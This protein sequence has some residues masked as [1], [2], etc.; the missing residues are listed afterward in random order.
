MPL[1]RQATEEHLNN[2]IFY[3]DDRH[4]MVR[5][6]ATMILPYVSK[7]TVLDCEHVAKALV[8]KFSFLTL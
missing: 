5:V 8:W 1:F 6:L 2:K 7:A 4:Y 3:P